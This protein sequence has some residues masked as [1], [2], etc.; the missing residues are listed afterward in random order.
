MRRA[1]NAQKQSAITKSLHFTFSHKN[2]SV[3][4][5]TSYHLMTVFRLDGN[6]AVFAVAGLSAVSSH[7]GHVST[8]DAKQP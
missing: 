1:Y 5:S 3:A 4:V 8:R 7:Y 6:G 2:K